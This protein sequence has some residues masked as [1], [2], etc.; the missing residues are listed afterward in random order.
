MWKKTI[1]CVLSL[2]AISGLATA[3]QPQPKSPDPAKTALIEEMISLT[4]PD[5]VITQFLQQYKAAFSKGLEE[6]FRNELSK[7]H[8]DASKYQPEIQRF[9]DQMFSL[10]ADRLKWE[11]IKPKFVVVYDETFSKQELSDIVA[12]YKTPSGQSLLQKMPE[13]IAKSSQIGQDQMIGA[14]AEI[15]RM[16][17]AFT[18][19]LL[20]KAHNREATQ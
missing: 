2:A 13:L 3:Q 11:K 4:H 16:T 14:T 1:I 8:E 20:K 18:N 7:H 19:D 12:F 15:Q 17:A 5:R 9:E 10:L 6:A